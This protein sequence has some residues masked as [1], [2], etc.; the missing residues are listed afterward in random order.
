[1]GVHHHCQFLVVGKKK[2]KS[3]IHSQPLS[4]FAKRANETLL[5]STDFIFKRNRVNSKM[6][7][8]FITGRHRFFNTG[9]HIQQWSC[10]S[11]TAAVALLGG[12][13][14][15]IHTPFQRHITTR[16]SRHHSQAH[17]IKS[18][19]FFSPSPISQK[20]LHNESFKYLLSRCSFH[21][22]PQSQIASSNILNITDGS[23]AAGLEN[24]ILEKGLSPHPPRA[25]GDNLVRCTVF[26]QQGSVKVISGEFKR[27]ELL[28]KHGLLP[29][30]LRKLDTGISSIVPSILV[31]KNSI[32]INLLHIRAL[33][34]ADMVI[35]F[36][37]YGST[38]SQT[39]SVFMYDLGHKL[40]HG[41]QSMGGL[42]Y[43][44]R[45]LEAIF[46]SV[47][48]ALDA[49][50]QVHTTVVNGILADLEDDI[51]REKLRYLLIQSKKLS[52]FLQKATLIRDTLDELLDQDEDLAGLYLTE[53]IQG[54]PR[55]ETDD[56]SEVEMLLESYYKHCDEIVQ[57]V[58]NL[59]SNIRST[60]EIVNIILD[61]NRN[62]L[63]LL[64][65]KFQIG[66]LGLGAGMF[67]ASLYGMNLE[68]FIEEANWGF[69]GVSGVVTVCT[70]VVIVI[71]L[72]NLYRVQRVTMMSSA[73]ARRKKASK[74]RLPLQRTKAP[75]PG[76]S[77]TVYPRTAPSTANQRNRSKV[78]NWLVQGPNIKRY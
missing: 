13:Y 10:L 61:A 57:T 29:R 21:S 68:N 73:D 55:D 5:D 33:V 66:T 76:G 28:S 7:S 59:A 32:L 72:K 1:M 60:E 36:D 11:K 25:I 18:T 30:D 12:A 43:E 24:L 47:M 71:S 14:S 27:S 42:P 8:G 16:A 65:L 67:I 3:E 2:F 39:Q 77:S 15:S 38:D 20:F 19:T 26:D 6:A 78:W 34:K 70:A 4:V 64:D 17:S 22:T 44:M 49:E 45:A 58:G 53:K 74:S 56:H 51:D 62:S 46:I 41:P 23:T 75:S 37:V 50:M 40:R 63:M 31:R 54:H 9:T 35:I 52:S 69:W 48:T